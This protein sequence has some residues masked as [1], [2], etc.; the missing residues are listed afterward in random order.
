MSI[1]KEGKF[2]LAEDDEDDEYQE[3]YDQVGEYFSK[4][5]G[6]KSLE[7]LLEEGLED[8]RN[9]RGKPLDQAMAD[10]RKKIGL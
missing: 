3:I 4:L 2:P 6:D 8:A 7:D 9:G 10:I 1:N 5:Y